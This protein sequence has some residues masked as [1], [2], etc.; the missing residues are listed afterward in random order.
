MPDWG[1]RLISTLY[2]IYLYF[3]LLSTHFVKKKKKKEVSKSSKGCTS[4]CFIFWQTINANSVFKK[5][6]KK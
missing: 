5:I 2:Y 1:W 4:H 3:F 6:L